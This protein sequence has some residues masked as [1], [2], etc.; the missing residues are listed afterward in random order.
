MTITASDIK[1]LI[2]SG[3]GEIKVLPLDLSIALTDQRFT[4]AG[5]QIGLWDA[6]N[7]TDIIYLRLNEQSRPQIP[8][9]RG[10]VLRVPF[11]EVYITVPAG[12]AGTAYIL[13]GTGDQAIL[14]IR[15]QVSEASEVLEDIRDELQGDQVPENWGNA[16]VGAAAVQILAANAN[17]RSFHVQSALGN[18]QTIWVGYANTVTNI[19]AAAALVAGQAFW[20]DD[21]RG[22]IYAIAGGAGQVVHYSEV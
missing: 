18:T 3:Q 10:K 5:T 22:P 15:P 20:L 8:F 19:N 2:E 4:I 14:G 21:Y 9:K 7:Q 6:P 13:Y 16:A 12:L 11:T 1:R 17:R